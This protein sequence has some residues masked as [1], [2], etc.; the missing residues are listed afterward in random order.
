MFSFILFI[1]GFRC[2]LIKLRGK[3]GKKKHNCLRRGCFQRVVLFWM[4]NKGTKRKGFCQSIWPPLHNVMSSSSAEQPSFSGFP[5]APGNHS[6]ALELRGEKI[7]VKGIRWL[8]CEGMKEGREEQ[9]GKPQWTGW[10]GYAGIWVVGK[11]EWHASH[12]WWLWVWN[13]E[14]V[15]ELRQ[16]ASQMRGRLRM[17]L[18]GC[19]RGS[20]SD[21]Q[22]LQ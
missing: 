20:R 12:R 18:W 6:L 11:R 14:P 22:E 13:F 5:L 21:T 4:G 2:A 19:V 10:L 3:I 17:W 7:S 1:K 9:S 15:K 16:P 8:K